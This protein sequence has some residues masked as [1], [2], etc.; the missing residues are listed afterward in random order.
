MRLRTPPFGRELRDRLQG[1]LVRWWGASPDGKAAPVFLL[2]G[3]EAWRVARE[4]E[5][6]RLLVLMPPAEDPATYDWSILRGHDPVLLCRCGRTEGDGVVML[7]KAIMAA[8]VLRVF[9]VATLQS[10][11]ARRSAA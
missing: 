10:Y 5:P 8:G 4:W 1:D 6:R 11:V 3:A 9:D 2:C 7:L